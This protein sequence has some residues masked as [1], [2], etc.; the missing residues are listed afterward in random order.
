MPVAPRWDPQSRQATGSEK[1]TSL[2]HRYLRPI[3][4]S[5]AIDRA[6]LDWLHEQAKRHIGEQRR[7]I[8]A[9]LGRAA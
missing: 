1:K 9:A 5:P 7:Q 8:E 6:L 3:P 2:P 4:Q